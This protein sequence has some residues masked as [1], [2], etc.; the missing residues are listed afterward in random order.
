MEFLNYH[1]L[2][3]MKKRFEKYA[4]SESSIILCEAIKKAIEIEKIK[5]TQADKE[6]RLEYQLNTVECPICGK[7]MKRASLYKHKQARHS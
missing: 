1:K 2:V 6:R 7:E 5:S 4:P 3:N